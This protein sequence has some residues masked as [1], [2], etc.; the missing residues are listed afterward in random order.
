MIAMYRLVRT[1]EQRSARWNFSF[2]ATNESRR[3]LSNNVLTLAS[4]YV[5]AFFF[6]WVWATISRA[7]QAV[8]GSIPFPLLVLFSLSLPGQ[9]L[10]NFFVYNRSRYLRY[11][12]KNPNAGWC[13]F[14][15]SLFSPRST[16]AVSKYGSSALSCGRNSGDGSH[17]SDQEGDQ[18]NDEPEANRSKPPNT[19]ELASKAASVQ[20]K[21]E[22]SN[23][24]NIRHCEVTS[25]A[26]QPSNLR[27]FA[28]RSTNGTEIESMQG[29]EHDREDRYGEDK[30]VGHLKVHEDA[31]SSTVTDIANSNITPVDMDPGIEQ[32]SSEEGIKH[33]PK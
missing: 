28:R 25:S 20:V 24:E 5:A 22:H 23:D 17:D 14:V 12:K 26:C 9:G 11:F 31:V 18:F 16:A 8:T 33:N 10:L 3:N 29:S 30:K 7:V 32:S 1:Q 13:N 15:P 4:W 6:T 21:I 19:D 2:R 27:P